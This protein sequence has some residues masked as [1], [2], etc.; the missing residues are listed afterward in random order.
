[1][2]FFCIVFEN[3]KPIKELKTKKAELQMPLPRLK[4]EIGKKI[5]I[6][7]ACHLILLKSLDVTFLRGR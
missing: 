2:I 7:K 3:L 4:Y 6:N 1:M 5:K